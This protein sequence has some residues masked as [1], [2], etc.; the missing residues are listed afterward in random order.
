MPKEGAKIGVE[1]PHSEVKSVYPE[2]V[3]SLQVIGIEAQIV[4]EIL[5]GQEYAETPYIDDIQ[6]FERDAIYRAALEDAV[7]AVKLMRELRG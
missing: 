6:D 2:P 7:N 5:Q 1:V 4:T 3:I